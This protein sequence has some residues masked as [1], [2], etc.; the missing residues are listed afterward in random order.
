MEVIGW[1]LIWVLF[2]ISFIG[3][4]YPIIPAVL[5]LAGGFVTYGLFFGFAELP[6]WFWAIEILFVV[7]L[8][9]ADL[10]ANALSVKRFGGSKAG[11]WGSTIGLII[12]PFVIP[13]VGILLGPFIGAIAAELIV[14]RTDLKQSVRSGV[15]S[16][17]GFLTSVAAKGIIQI[18]MIVIF[19][20]AV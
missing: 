4:V 3:L 8:F 18:V 19:F 11:L 1:T 9:G 16:V 17:V 15:G 5:F 6:W 13:V 2:V 7:L 14:N 10:L 20:V 12:G